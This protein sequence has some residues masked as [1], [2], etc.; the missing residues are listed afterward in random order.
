MYKRLYHYNLHKDVK[1]EKENIILNVTR[2]HTKNIMLTQHLICIKNNNDS[3]NVNDYYSINNVYEND[4]DV[5]N[6]Y[7][8]LM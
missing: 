4:N 3:N 5:M 8:C 7:S 6:T 1:S 2:Y